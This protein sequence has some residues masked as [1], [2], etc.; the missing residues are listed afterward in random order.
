MPIQATYTSVWN[1]GTAVS[2][3]CK[4]DPKTKRVFDIQMSDTDVDDANLDSEYVTLSD[5]T[6]LT[7]DDGVTF[8]Y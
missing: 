3:S 5:G 4:Y 8:D 1:N 6:E 7:S 2:T